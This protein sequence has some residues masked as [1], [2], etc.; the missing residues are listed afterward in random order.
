V[1][2]T[3]VDFFCGAGGSSQGFAAIPG[4]EVLAAANH[5]DRALESHAANFPGATH[6]QGDIREMDMSAFPRGDIFWASPECPTW[7][8]A[9][10]KQRD[11]DKQPDLFGETLPDEATERSRALMWDVPRYLEAMQLRGEPVLAGV[12]ENVTDVRAWD[13]WRSWIDS[14]EKLGYRTRLIA[15]NSMHA[16]PR[17]SLLAPQSRDRLYLAYWATSLGRDPNW[18]KWLRPAAHCPSCGD[19]VSALQVFK[20]AGA[21]MGRYRQQYLYRC[22]KVSCRSQIVEPGY[23]PAAAAIDWNL[24]GK[25]IGDR[26]KPLS[27]KTMA[28]IV[29]GFERYA[30]PIT[31][32]AAGNTYERRPGVRTWPVD[33]PMP[34]R[35]CRDNDGVALPPFLTINRGAPDELRTS[36]IDD[37]LSTVTTAGTQHALVV[38]AFLTPLRSG[39]PRTILADREPLATI[40]ADGAGHGLVVPPFLTIM[41]G[42]SGNQPVDEPIGTLTTLDHHG[43]VAP[44]LM[45]PV[46]GR[47]GKEARPVTDPHRTQS[48]RAETGI[49]MPPAGDGY[50]PLAMLMR[51]NTPRGNAA[52]MCSPVTEAARTFTTAGH[53]SLVSWQHLLV[54][55]YGTGVAHQVAEPIGTLTAKARYAL[56]A[57]A[58]DIN[59]ALF[60]MLEPHE[61][62]RATAFAADYKVFGSKREMT[63]QYGNAVTPPVSEVIGCA[64]VECILGEDLAAA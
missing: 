40:V 21:D 5:W 26:A 27:P 42:R 63:R 49:V 38:P 1:S 23:L 52:Q 14:I 35:T 11:Y 13:R 8:Q 45:V 7:S 15:L 29:A 25:R 17:V 34:A 64:L 30:R 57:G 31:L 22:P 50:I 54:P 56:V 18:D 32:E 16:R 33:E 2:L 28:R 3:L 60:R 46:E 10:G 37:P 59:D 12:V 48:A 41:R 6:Y 19:V 61:I 51:N 55:Y 4:I 53:Q 20:K 47:D 43:L 39:R 62:G 24:P 9:R 36:Q 58:F 44:P